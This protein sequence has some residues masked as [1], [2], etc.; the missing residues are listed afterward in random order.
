M[1]EVNQSGGQPEAGAAGSSALR[2]V[3]SETAWSPSGTAIRG[4]AAPAAPA[5]A[6]EAARGQFGLDSTAVHVD[7]QA[8]AG[9]LAYDASLL[10]G[11]GLHIVEQYAERVDEEA[12]WGAVYLL[13]QAEKVLAAAAVRRSA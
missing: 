8:G 4:E 3:Q 7:P 10:L 5:A 1:S 9:D 2:L 11:C 6:P 12:L 13:R